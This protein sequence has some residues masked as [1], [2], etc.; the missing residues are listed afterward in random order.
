MASR[1]GRVVEIRSG[2]R[3][4]IAIDCGR[5]ITPRY[6]YSARGVRFRTRDTA[7][8]VLAAI[9]VAIAGE[10]SPQR[11]VE[12]YA[13]ASGKRA[14]VRYWLEEYLAE[15][16]DR[17]E[18]GDLSPTT[19]RELE[20]YAESHFR[21]FDQMTLS[22]VDTAEVRAFA[23]KLSKT[24]RQKDPTRTIGPK[25]V[26]NILGAFHAFMKWLLVL[27]R[28]ERIPVFP[29]IRVPEHSP[30]IISIRTQGLVLDAIPWELRGAFIAAT[31]GMRP[32]EIRALNQSDWSVREDAEGKECLGLVISKAM[33]GP[34][35]NSVVGSTKNRD[36]GWIPIGADLVE[37]IMWRQKQT[38]TPWDSRAMFVNP[39]ALKRPNPEYRWIS[40]SL[41]ERWNLAAESVGVRV[42]MYEGTKHSSATAWRSKGVHLETI[43]RM[44]RHRDSRSTERY[45]KLADGA[46]VE[47]F[48]RVK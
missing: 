11:A 44:L 19:V 22:E 20:H 10:V 6:L 7:E 16:R 36:M 34:N 23:R 12:R 15:C 25:T 13:P 4:R 26:R 43:Q 32:N 30:T 41:R 9:R 29:T 2:S 47:A 42:K 38:G 48:R 27:E 45:A 35:A 33:K 17:C 31:Y 21:H 18:A 24:P 5:G 3:V 28:I 39:R 1:F 46:L 14:S 8:A 40:N 37:W